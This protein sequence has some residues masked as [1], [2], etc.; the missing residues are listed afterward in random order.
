MNRKMTLVLFCAFLF[1]STSFAA[2]TCSAPASPMLVGMWENHEIS[3]GGIGSAIEFRSD[4]SVV[5]AITVIVNST[6]AISGDQ[7]MVSTTPGEKPS[8]DTAI[9]FKANATKFIR[10]APNGVE[11]PAD[12]I[13]SPVAGVSS[14]VGSWRYRHATGATTYEHY[15]PDGRL[16]LRVPMPNTTKIGCYTV[17]AVK[18]TTTIQWP[19]TISTLQFEI[20]GGEIKLTRT[21]GK[22]WNSSRSEWGSWYD[23]EHVDYVAPGTSSARDRRG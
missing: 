6:Y 21:D 11:I 18:R 1:S 9:H 5:Q 7:F 23:I 14:I 13:G 22:S 15:T 3:K 2:T 19:N 16:A 4:G 8:P 12:R 20:S 17:N 10:Y